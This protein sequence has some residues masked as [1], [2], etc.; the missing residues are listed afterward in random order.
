MGQRLGESSVYS[1]EAGF[2]EKY[3]YVNGGNGDGQ[4]EYQGW[5]AAGTATTTARWRIRKFT[6]DSS[7]RTTDIQWAAGTD[8]FTTAWDSRTSATYS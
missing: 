8:E 5:A 6:Y 4:I 3:A 7:N 2:T 1:R